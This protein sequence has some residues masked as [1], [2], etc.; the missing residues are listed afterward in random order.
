MMVKLE[1]EESSR[2]VNLFGGLSNNNLK[3]H[4]PTT[5]PQH[6]RL[7]IIPVLEILLS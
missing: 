5:P 6:R 2:L 4:L 7:H 1:C 3:L